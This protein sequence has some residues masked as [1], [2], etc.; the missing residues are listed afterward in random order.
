MLYSIIVPVYNRPDEIQDLLTCLA[1]QTFTN[2]EVLIIE[3]GSTI[4]SDEVVKSFEDKLTI[5]YF[6]KGNDGQ[7]FSRNYGFARASGDYFIVLDSDVL[8]D[9][10]F[11]A[12]IDQSLTDNYLDCYGGPDKAHHSFTPV[13][14]AIN[15]TL[16][17]F[18]TTGGIRGH[19]NHVGKFYPRSFN[20]GFSRKVYEATQGFKIPFFG[21]D[22]ELSARIMALGFKVGLIPSAHVYHKRKT[23]FSD[24]YKQ[25]NF[26]GRSRI[27]IYKMF[28]DSLKFTHFVPALFTMY[29]IW[30]AICLVLVPGVS[31][32]GFIPYCCYLLLIFIDASAQNNSIRIGFLSLK[33]LFTQMFGYGIGFIQDFV[34]RVILGEE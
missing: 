13:Q 34:R 27:N 2:F 1:T 6:F 21:E 16:T 17:S 28:P 14:K 19:K 23:N 4:K 32:F 20:M 9:D 26:F 10:D 33:A 15:Y 22:I 18:F 3:S 7:G 11:V 5:K 30:L 8:L 29:S 31:V 12:Q 24:F 25:M